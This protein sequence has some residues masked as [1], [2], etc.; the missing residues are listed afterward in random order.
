MTSPLLCNS[1]I[2]VYLCRAGC[3]VRSCWCFVLQVVEAQA[4]GKISRIEKLVL[5]ELSLPHSLL[6][7][8]FYLKR[9]HWLHWAAAHCNNTKEISAS[10]WNHFRQGNGQDATGCLIFMH[11]SWK[12]RLRLISLYCQA[13]WRG[14]NSTNFV[15]LQRWLEYWSI[16]P[17]RKSWG[18]WACLAWRREGWEGTL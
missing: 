10:H 5:E 7:S 11:F 3:G 15:G 14:G 1:R 2:S 6:P 18:S 13:C 12:L 16:S 9:K 4:W 17:M 8:L